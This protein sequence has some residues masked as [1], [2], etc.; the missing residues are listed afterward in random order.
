MHDSIAE[1]GQDPAEAGEAF[2][3]LFLTTPKRAAKVIAKGIERDRRRVLIGPDA[4]AIS[5]LSKLPPVAYQKAL[6]R[7][8]GRVEAGLGATVARSA[9]SC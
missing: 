2:E 6:A 5:L 8:A 4:W 9:C 7:G 1:L 3:Q